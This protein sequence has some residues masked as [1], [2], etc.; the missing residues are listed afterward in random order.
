MK[1]LTVQKGILFLVCESSVIDWEFERGSCEETE[2]I[3]LS[4]AFTGKEMKGKK[5]LNVHCSSETWRPN[6]AQTFKS[7]SVYIINE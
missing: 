5:D 2:G 3:S 6:A 4:L 1:R 7:L